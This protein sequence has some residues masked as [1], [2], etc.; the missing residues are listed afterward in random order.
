MTACSTHERVAEAAVFTLMYLP[1]VFVI[2]HPI[3]NMHV[4]AE[5][6]MALVQHCTCDPFS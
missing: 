6:M 3:P 5:R 2:V 4:Y 1:D